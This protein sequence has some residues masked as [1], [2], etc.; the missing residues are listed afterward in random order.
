LPPP[1]S[2]L[3]R[4]SWRPIL[5]FGLIFGTEPVVA[6]PVPAHSANPPRPSKFQARIE[7]AARALRENNPR[8]KNLSREYVQG[9]AEF[10]SGNMLFVLLHEM[11]HVSITQMGLPVLGRMEDAADTYLR[12]IRVGSDFS[13]RVLTDAAEGRFMADRRD[14]KTS[15]KVAYYDEHGLDQQRAYQSCA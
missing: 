7:A 15:D 13:H 10:V 9:L 1:G 3:L 8:F 11:A 6:Q 5:L 12:L 14:Q 2:A 4:L